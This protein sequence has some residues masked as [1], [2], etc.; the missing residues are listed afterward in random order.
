MIQRIPRSRRAIDEIDLNRIKARARCLRDIRTFFDDAGYVEIEPPVLIPSPGLEPHIDAFE[1]TVG[2]QTDY[3]QTSPEYAMKT[4]LGAG[5]ERI[6]TLTPCFRDEPRSATHSPQFTMLEWYRTGADLFALMD[7]TEA[8]IKSLLTDQ[9]GY[10][11]TQATTLL[12]RPFERITVRD[13]FVRHAELDPWTFAEVDDFAEAARRRGYRVS[14]LDDDWDSVFFAVF[15]E[16]VEP[17]LGVEAA[18]LLWGWPASQAA[19]ARLDP[20]DPSRALRFELYAGGFE[21]ANA[22]DELVCATEQK[23]RLKHEQAERQR[24]GRPVY[25]IDERFLEGVHR[26]HPTEGIALG[27]DRLLMCLTDATL[28]EEVQS[29]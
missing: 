2:N 13:A 12:S 8:L 16:A 5:L 3:L 10:A 25:P 4:L 7:E 26:M 21:L 19:L 29:W 18:T 17:A 28:I 11:S 14:H 20:N 15:M 24:R 22:F 9:S 23:R 27:V 1:V 6:Y